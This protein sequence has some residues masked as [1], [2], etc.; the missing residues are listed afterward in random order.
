MLL[1]KEGIDVN[2]GNNEGISPLLEAI[3]NKNTDSVNIL[4]QA[5]ADVNQADKNGNTPLFISAQNG[6]VD[7]TKMLREKEGIDVNKGNNEEIS[8]LLKAIYKKKTDLVNICFKLVL[9]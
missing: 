2:K 3:Y 8:P 1:E 5:G 7:I 4:L 9:M 6:E